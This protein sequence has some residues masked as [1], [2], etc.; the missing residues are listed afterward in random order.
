MPLAAYPP[1]CRRKTPALYLGCPADLSET[2]FGCLKLALGIEGAVGNPTKNALQA[3]SQSWRD[4]RCHGLWRRGLMVRVS[5]APVRV[6]AVTPEGHKIVL[7]AIA[8]VRTAKGAV[9]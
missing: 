1:P 5:S 8:R 6:F 3:H 9:S 4:A 2:D 7:A